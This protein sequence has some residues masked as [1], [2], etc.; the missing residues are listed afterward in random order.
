MRKSLSDQSL[1]RL[2][3]KRGYTLV[4]PWCSERRQIDGPDGGDW[5]LVPHHSGMTSEE[6]ERVLRAE[7]QSGWSLN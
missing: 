6:V 7:R 3:R 2:A 5:V 4:K 1:R